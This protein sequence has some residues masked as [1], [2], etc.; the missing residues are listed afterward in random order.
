M[1]LRRILAYAAVY[2]LWGGTYLAVR[3]VVLVTPPFT[4]AALRF[5]LSGLLLL[6]ISRTQ[7]A[8]APTLADWRHSAKLGFVMFA[9]NYAC[10]FWAE[11]RLYS[12]LAAVIVATMPVWIFLAEWLITR[13]QRL[14]VG[15]VAGIALGIAG[16]ALLTHHNT[17]AIGSNGQTNLAIGVL[18]TGTLCWSAGSVWSRALPLPSNQMVRSA[19]Q[20][21]TGGVFLCFLAFAVGDAHRILSALEQWT[22]T[23]WICFLYLIAASILA[24]TAYTWLLEHEPA[25]RV[26]SYAYV[27]PLVAMTLG[28]WLG[29]EH[30][31]PWQITGATLVLL[32][33]VAT[34]TAKHHMSERS[35]PPRQGSSE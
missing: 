24:F 17:P 6:A 2:L 21:T 11:Q 31:G 12:G 27:N 32:S 4:A 28:A 34:L 26:A 25:G 15:I 35:I 3:T 13:N 29:N 18:L 9:I 33:V 20:M 30:F 23:T 14:S 10:F 5:L 16:V 7:G 1:K 22:T 8:P 19:L